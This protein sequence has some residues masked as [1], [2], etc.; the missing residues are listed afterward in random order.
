MRHLP[1]IALLALVIISLS[2]LNSRADDPVSAVS[3]NGS[4]I[5]HDN[6]S[7][8]DS[9][10][11][12]IDAANIIENNPLVRV[13]DGFVQVY[14]HCNRVNDDDLLV[15]ESLGL[16]TEIVNENLK[17][18]QGWISQD[19]LE[20]LENLDFIK[21]VTPPVYGHTKVGEVTSE[22]D[23]ILNA[24]AAR[25]A[26]GVDGTGVRI[27]VISDGV[28]GLSFSQLTGDLPGNVEVIDG[29]S[30]S[31][32][33][34]LLEITHDLAPGAQLVFTSGFPTSMDFIAAIGELTNAGVDIIVDDLGF[35]GEPF[36]E[37]GPV[38]DAAA[39]AVNQGIIFIS[40]AGNDANRH[41]QAPFVGVASEEGY[42]LQDFGAAAGE[43]SDTQMRVTIS[44]G[45]I[46]FVFLQWTDP[47]G[48][49]NTDFDLIARNPITGE[50]I[51]IG[52]NIQ[53]GNDDPEEIVGLMNPSS[54]STAIFDLEI[55]FKNG[56]SA[57]SNFP[58]AGSR[59]NGVNEL[60]EIYFNS[61]SGNEIHRGWKSGGKYQLC[62]WC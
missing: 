37:D 40:A 61:L 27:G 35:L 62:T 16:K 47:F 6:N 53:D 23:S 9:R 55:D 10:L 22:G 57:S 11:K 51:D 30:G 42:V 33:T 38:A 58:N 39:N 12:S 8:I 24:D 26:F 32:G 21:K 25:E 36:F 14:V 28:D 1:H 49:S 50:I 29:G 2:G 20:E 5:I 18:V 13:Q 3:I 7:K 17:I 15:L 44:P 56:E 54:S 34:A 46:V 4:D 41:Y 19:N 43:A 31:E 52:N 45:A 48:L 60:V 59:A